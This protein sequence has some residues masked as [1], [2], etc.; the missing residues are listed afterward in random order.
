MTEYEYKMRM[1]WATCHLMPPSTR[2]EFGYQ[3]LLTVD[4]GQMLMLWPSYVW[5]TSAMGTQ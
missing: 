5:D 2:G 1:T 4:L 3:H